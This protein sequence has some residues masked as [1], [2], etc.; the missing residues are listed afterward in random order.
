M[1]N[2][3]LFQF[4]GLSAVI[5]VT[6]ELL[7]VGMYENM[8]IVDGLRGRPIVA[9]LANIFGSVLLLVILETPYIGE[10][11]STVVP[12]AS[13]CHPFVEVLVSSQRLASD[14]GFIAPEVI[15]NVFVV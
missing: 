6:T 12:I 11:F 7:F 4:E 8:V 13:K 14:E 3:L 15:A 5:D 10:H 2:R 9:R 1:V